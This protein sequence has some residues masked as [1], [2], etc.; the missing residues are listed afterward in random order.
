MV[1]YKNKIVTEIQEIA[2]HKN[3]VEILEECDNS[4]LN[5]LER[6]YIEKYN[7]IYPDGYNDNEGGD[8]GFHHSERTKRKI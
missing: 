3:K 2:C 6:I 1:D 7:T 4:K 5:E 8:I